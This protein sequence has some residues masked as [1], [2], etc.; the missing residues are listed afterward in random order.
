[1]NE[2]DLPALFVNVGILVL[3]GAMA[4]VA[5]VQARAALHDAEAAKNAKNEAV[6]AQKASA[7]ALVEANQIAKDALDAQRRTLPAPWGVPFRLGDDKS[8]YGIPNTSGQAVI[9]NALDVEGGDVKLFFPQDLPAYV[10]YGDVLTF[11]AISGDRAGAGAVATIG[12]SV[13]GD[14]F[15]Y[16]T[17]RHF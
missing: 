4:L 14:P 1:M 17:K 2:T 12:W 3:T 6:A 5:F 9:V 13:E 7:T 11:T 15:E 16:K 8:G 10:E